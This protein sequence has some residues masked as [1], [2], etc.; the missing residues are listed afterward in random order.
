M[1]IRCSVW[2]EMVLFLPYNT[3]RQ[4]KHRGVG[5]LDVEWGAKRSFT[6]DSE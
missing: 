6:V 3:N 5:V 1:V 4:S 2:S